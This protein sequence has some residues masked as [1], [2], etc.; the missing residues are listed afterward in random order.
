MLNTVK[1]L[2]AV[3]AREQGAQCRPL[4]CQHCVAGLWF[5]HFVG[6]IVLAEFWENTVSDADF[7]SGETHTL[8]DLFVG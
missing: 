3:L 8:V 1:L 2:S 6:D 4:S 5:K 7:G